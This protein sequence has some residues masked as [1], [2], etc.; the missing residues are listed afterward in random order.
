[1]DPRACADDQSLR[2]VA[3]QGAE[4][5]GDV[6]LLANRDTDALDLKLAAFRFESWQKC[7]AGYTFRVVQKPYATQVR[8]DFAQQIQMLDVELCVLVAQPGHI[9][10]GAS[11]A[12]G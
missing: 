7:D 5:T 12:R 3:L 1:G 11:Q 6:L 2:F 9:P 8:N 10:S 4:R